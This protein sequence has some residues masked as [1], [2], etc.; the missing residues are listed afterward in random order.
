MYV[1]M[2]TIPMIPTHCSCHTALTV[3]MGCGIALATFVA[4]GVF[5]W[6]SRERDLCKSCFARRDDRLLFLLYVSLAACG[7]GSQDEG[8]RKG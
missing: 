2:G 7:T 3:R 5:W 4:S 8:K 6:M 1:Y